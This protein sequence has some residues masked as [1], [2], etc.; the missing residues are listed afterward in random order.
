MT[1]IDAEEL[2]GWITIETGAPREAVEAVLALELEYMVGAGIVDIPG[3]EP[4]YYTQDELKGLPEGEV[5]I[6]RLSRDAENKLR[7]SSDIA[8]SILEKE[9][10]FL[11]R[12]GLVD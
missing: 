2:A 1:E 10:E 12:E 3:F 9:T 5:D 4:T 6:E 11:A 8:Q 7:V